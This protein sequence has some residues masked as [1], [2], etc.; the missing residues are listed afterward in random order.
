VIHRI[1]G[2]FLRSQVHCQ[3]CGRD[4]NTDDPMLG[5]TLATQSSL[6]KAFRKYTAKEH[7]TG[8]EK[9]FCEHCKKKQDAFK[10]MMILKPPPVLAVHLKRFEFS[11]SGNRIK[12]SQH[13]EFEET[14]NLGP[15]VCDPRRSEVNYELSAVL[16][17]SGNSAYGG[18]YYSYVRAPGNESKRWYCM[19]DSSVST[20]NIAKVLRT[21][22][23]I[24]MYTM[25]PSTLKSQFKPT[26]VE[27]KSTIIRQVKAKP[28]PKTDAKLDSVLLSRIFPHGYTKNAVK[29]KSDFE[30]LQE[31][32]LKANDAS[33]KKQ[34][35]GLVLPHKA[36]P[37]TPP[38]RVEKI[39]K[40]VIKRTVEIAVRPSPK[41]VSRKRKLQSK[42]IYEARWRKRRI[43]SFRHAIAEDPNVLNMRRKHKRTPIEVKF[44]PNSEKTPAKRVFTMKGLSS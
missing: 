15:F 6:K 19:N 21:Q 27:K 17:H 39:V 44:T 34:A 33:A 43:V 1:W 5:I 22:A 18:H 14:L 7:L 40:P 37:P 2:G 29:K 38:R 11:K 24:V 25:T 8:S 9:Y 35:T 10:R 20:V 32:L 13:V 42:R 26:R 3:T 12:K 41:L 4:S 30:K 28:Q 31:S 23:Y 36:D 16:V